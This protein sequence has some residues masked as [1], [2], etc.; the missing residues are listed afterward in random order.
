MIPVKRVC[1]LTK[2]EKGLSSGKATHYPG[3]LPRKWAFPDDWEI[4]LLLLSGLREGPKPSGLRAREWW[5]FLAPLDP[6]EKVVVILR[7]VWGMPT[8]TIGEWYGV[9][10]TAIFALERRALG[11]L[12]GSADKFLT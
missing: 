11:K 5:A 12:K 8:D 9:T 3:N 4:V 7:Y 10:R 6:R 2:R 1:G